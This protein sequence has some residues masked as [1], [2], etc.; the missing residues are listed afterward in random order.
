MLIS[1]F[2]GSIFCCNNPNC[3]DDNVLDV[4]D[5]YCWVMTVMGLAGEAGL[6][7]GMPG[8]NQRRGN[9]VPIA[10]QCVSAF[11]LAVSGSECWGFESLRAY[12]RNTVNSFWIDGVPV[13]F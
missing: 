10:V 8:G 7:G 5:D 6:S 12:H 11:N 9:A 2:N 3:L 1:L 4:L 13:L